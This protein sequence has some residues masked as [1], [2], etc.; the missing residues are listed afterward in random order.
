MTEQEVNY[1]NLGYIPDQY[2]WLFPS[3]YPEAVPPPDWSGLPSEAGPTSSPAQDT[4]P[5]ITLDELGQLLNE[6]QT[7]GENQAPSEDQPSE[8]APSDPGDTVAVEL[9]AG[10]LALIKAVNDVK[11]ELIQ[12]SDQLADMQLSGDR[13]LLMTSFSDYTVTEGLLLLLLLAA[14][15]A[16]CA[17][18]LK[19]GLSWLKS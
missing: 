10:D 19:G 11:T 13:P 15:A 2:P 3:L 17:K 7:A 18:I 8:E 12:I 14:F 5:S 6:L 1:I 9:E 4:S 16:A